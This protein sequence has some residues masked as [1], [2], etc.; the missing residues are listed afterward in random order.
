MRLTRYFPAFVLAFALAACG[1]GNAPTGDAG[2]TQA[3]DA[4]PSAKPAAVAAD[5]SAVAQAN[6]TRPLQVSD[7]DAYAKGMDKEIELRKEASDKAIKAKAAKD[8]QAEVM[9]IV[10]MTSAEI[11]SAG[12]RAAGMDAARYAF[13]KHAIDRVLGSV[14]M[15]KA[16]AKMEGGAQMQQ[17]LGDPYAGLD[18]DVA[19]ALKAREGELG[20]LRE[21]NMAILANAQNL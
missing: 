9:A 4:P 11:E 3:Q 18:A 17:K 12:A 6:A 15:G 10:E 5:P 8:Q 21:D 19:S 20:K 14:W 2:G 7:L 16:M 1:H 13:V